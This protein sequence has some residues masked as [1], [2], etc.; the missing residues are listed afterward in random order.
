MGGA[1][2]VNTWLMKGFFDTVPIELDESAKMDGASH[3]VTFFRVI[4]PL[5]TPILAVVGVLSFIGAI[6]EYLLASVFLTNDDSKTLAVGLFGLVAGERNANFG[7]FAAGTLLTAIPARSDRVHRPGPFEDWDAPP[8]VHG[9]K[10]GDLYGVIEHLDH[11][12]RLG[13]TALYL[14]PIFQ[15]ASNHRYHTFDYLA[16]DPL[17][18]GDAALRELLDVCH[19]RGMRVVLD[20]VF[21]HASRG[22]WAFHHI[23]EHGLASPYLDWFFIDREALARGVPIRA[24]PLE[25]VELDMS[26]IT[27]EQMSGRASPGALRLPRLVGSLPALPKLNVA[28]PEVREHL[29]QAAEHWIRFGPTAG[30]STSRARCPTTSGAS[31]AAG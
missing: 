29:L 4:L 26:A 22:F 2:G 5:V 6:N 25:P 11:I 14:N 31:S 28:N 9:F 3:A 13:A 21:N 27:P 19:A 15:S 7:V 12:Q 1:L 17:L 8:T 30:G 10:G 20:G 16:V 18:G 23:L 24:Y